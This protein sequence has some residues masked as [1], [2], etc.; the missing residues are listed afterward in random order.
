[1]SVAGNV[2]IVSVT[3]AQVE[4]LMSFLKS[5]AENEERINMAIRGFNLEGSSKGARPQKTESASHSRRAIPTTAGLVNCKSEK[6]RVSFVRGHTT[7][8]PAKRHRV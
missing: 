2:A 7:A 3:L 1:M 4:S 5:E 6:S 8:S